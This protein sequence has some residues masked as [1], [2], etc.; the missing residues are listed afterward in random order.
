MTL[1]KRF[2]VFLQQPLNGEHLPH[3]LSARTLSP[4]SGQFNFINSPGICRDKTVICDF[5][6][7][8]AGFSRSYSGLPRPGFAGHIPVGQDST[9]AASPP[10][11]RGQFSEGRAAL[12]RS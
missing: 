5:I 9:N 4:R 3:S 10:Q 1:P 7:A 6:P 2:E 8:F 12:Y 11:S